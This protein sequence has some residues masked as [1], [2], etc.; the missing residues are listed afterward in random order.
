[1]S[2]RKVE[3]EPDLDHAVPAVGLGNQATRALLSD[4][5]PTPALAEHLRAGG[6]RTV[7]RWVQARLAVGPAGDPY[8]R[9]ADRVAMG[10]SAVATPAS[11]TSP[12]GLATA[13]PVVEQ[14]VS[15][16]G[17]PLD[18]GIR[19]TMEGRFG[20]DFSAVRVHPD[21]QANEIEDFVVRHGLNDQ[22]LNFAPTGR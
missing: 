7:S 22:N 21:S 4:P 10:G 13:P 18:P 14:A 15:A 19:A 3:A 9:E 16:D 11:G 12:G 2:G 20:T 17:Q 6:N 5:S 1:M 8:E